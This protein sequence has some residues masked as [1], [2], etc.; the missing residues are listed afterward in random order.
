MRGKATLAVSLI[1]YGAIILVGFGLH[2]WDMLGLESAAKGIP[3]LS[4]QKHFGATVGFVLMAGIGWILLGSGVTLAIATGG[5]NT[6]M[7][8]RACRPA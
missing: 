2:V 5:S 3:P 1:L 6:T 8:P 7:T 4:T